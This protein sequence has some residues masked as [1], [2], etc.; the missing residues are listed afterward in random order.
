M[1]GPNRENTPDIITSNTSIPQ[2]IDR[3]AESGCPD[4][5]SDL[6]LAR[7][8][9]WSVNGGG[10]GDIYEGRLTNGEQVAIKTIR[11]DQSLDLSKGNILFKVFGDLKA[12]NVLIGPD[13]TAKI[14][15]F[16]LSVLGEATCMFSTTQSSGGGSLRWMAPELI[17]DPTSKRSY[18]ADVYALAMEIL[19]NEFPFPKLDDVKIIYAI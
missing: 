11:G 1:S 14:T 12:Q 9:Q 15:D 18:E 8:S 5:T 10:Q 19:T 4:L 17:S 13:G 6:D 7:C 2:I 3:L 16:G